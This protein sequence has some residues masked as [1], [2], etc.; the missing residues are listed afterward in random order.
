MR[1]S[2]YLLSEVFNPWM[3]GVALLAGV[4]AKNRRPLAKDHPLIVRERKVTADITRI[5]HNF[6]E[7]RDAIHEHTFSALFGGGRGLGHGA[8]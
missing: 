1:T 7:A 2:R 8:N 3:C 5:L 4:V 6:R